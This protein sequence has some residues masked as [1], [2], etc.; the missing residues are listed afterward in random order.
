MSDDV[1]SNGK[2]NAKGKM[3]GGITGKGM[4]PGE[5]RNPGGRPKMDPELKR[6]LAADALPT[7]REAWALYREAKEG[8]DLRVAKDILL[9]LLRKMIPD[10]TELLVAAPDGGPVRVVNVDPRKLT[11]EQL[12]ALLALREE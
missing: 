7:Y 6:V 9:G 5:T 11:T 8:G 10:T 3:L 2:N 12:D 4:M 1:E